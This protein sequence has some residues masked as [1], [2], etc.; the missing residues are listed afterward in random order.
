MLIL[1]YP[2]KSV[3]QKKQKYKKL[4]LTLKSKDSEI[5]PRI[6]VNGKLLVFKQSQD[7]RFHSLNGI[8][9]DDEFLRI[10]DQFQ[11]IM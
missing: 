9:G 7:K 4:I 11:S 10:F 2:K 5:L 1:S 8:K 6:S 3:K